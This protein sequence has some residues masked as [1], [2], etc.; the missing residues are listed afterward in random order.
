ML[1]EREK[2][3]VLEVLNEELYKLSEIAAREGL[4]SNE[5][6]EV[7]ARV[8]ERWSAALRLHEQAYAIYTTLGQSAV[9]AWVR[10]EHPEIGWEHCEPCESS[11]PHH[12]GAC[13]VCANVK[14]AEEAA[15]AEGLR[16]VQDVLE[17]WDESDPAADR[18][19]ASGL[20]KA[21]ASLLDRGSAA[22]PTSTG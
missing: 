21:L 5:R 6:S 13:L 12:E 17:S 11:E 7:L 2:E 22:E 8:I 16:W 14:R 19:A 1:N 20:A 4:D 15:L 10:Q 9:E 18:D 3:V